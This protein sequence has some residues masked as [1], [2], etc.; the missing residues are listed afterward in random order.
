MVG[1]EG[2]R[3]GR[4]NNLEYERREGEVN[5]EAQDTLLVPRNASRSPLFFFS[6]G[7]FSLASENYLPY[8]THREKDSI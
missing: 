4:M 8:T 5:S 6:Q 3:F 1:R 7:H 2:G